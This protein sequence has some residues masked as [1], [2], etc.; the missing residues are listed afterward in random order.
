MTSPGLAL[1]LAAADLYANSWRLMAV[2]AAL[3]AVL[4]AVGLAAF[5]VHAALVLVVLAGPVA[6]ALV[7]CAVTLV[8]TGNVVVAD[9]V[10]GLRLHWRRGLELGAGGAALLGL[11]ALAVRFYAGT[12]YG[13]PFVFVT[14][15]L[16]LLLGVFQLIVWTLA[17]AE[18]GRTL[19]DACRDAAV[20]T[21]RRPSATLLLGLAL[22]LVNVLGLAAAVMPFLTLT[23]AYSFVAVARFA[24]PS[25]TQESS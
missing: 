1:R 21:A 4:V 20:L 6:A 24:L 19:R 23:V 12:S 5:A 13:W 16:L 25:P 9:A 15:Y 22:L 8:R 14:I 17:V 7:H 10:E 3:G 18:P 11:G 2:N